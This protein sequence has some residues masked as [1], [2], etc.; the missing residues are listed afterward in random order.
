[1]SSSPGVPGSSPGIP[2]SGGMPISSN[3]PPNVPTA[4][5]AWR[6]QET[7]RYQRRKTSTATVVA[8]VVAVLLVV[9]A[10]VGGWVIT[11]RGG[12]AQPQPP[13]TAR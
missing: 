10:G 8:F 7:M 1:M 3:M 2:S 13:S 12:P 5:A 9:L 4:P 6:D 11:S